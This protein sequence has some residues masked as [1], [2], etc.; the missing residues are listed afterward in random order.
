MTTGINPGIAT[1]PSM[2]YADALK[3][4]ESLGSRRIVV[5][6]PDNLMPTGDFLKEAYQ[7]V[8][9]H[10]HDLYQWA[11]S[12]LP[13]VSG[14]LTSAGKIAES[15]IQTAQDTLELAGNTAQETLTYAGNMISG[16]YP[17]VGNIVKGA[18]PYIGALTKH[19][20]PVLT[21]AAP[22]AIPLGQRLVS[23]RA[24][25]KQ[26]VLLEDKNQRVKDYLLS[27]QNSVKDKCHLANKRAQQLQKKRLHY[28]RLKDRKLIS[29][30]GTIKCLATIAVPLWT[31]GGTAALG[32]GLLGLAARYYTNRQEASANEAMAE[33]IKKQEALFTSSANVYQQELEK[34][35]VLQKEAE[36]LKIC[37]DK[38]QT[39]LTRQQIMS[40]QLEGWGGDLQTRLTDAQIHFSDALK[41]KQD[42]YDQLKTECDQLKKKLKDGQP[43]AGGQEKQCSHTEGK[44]NGADNRPLN[45]QGDNKPGNPAPP[46]P[47]PPPP[48]QT[49]GDA[50]KNINNKATTSSK[51]NF[52]SELTDGNHL[53]RLKQ[54]SPPIAK[55]VTK[56]PMAILMDDIRKGAILNP[57]P[58]PRDKEDYPKDMSPRDYLMA[59]L[60]T[61]NPLGRLNP[62]KDK[63]KDKN[64]QDKS[65]MGFFAKGLHQ[66]FFRANGNDSMSSIDSNDDDFE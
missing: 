57:A 42:Q 24:H 17:V 15:T 1:L 66:K 48:K 5:V 9:D 46:P 11:I 56:D 58:P 32:A 52:V 50:G 39:D 63:D 6:D 62:I 38:L 12:S 8:C 45:G 61:D 34:D 53:G 36:L 40:N 35:G 4:L 20:I 49:S 47:P 18:A 25:Q 30:P 3:Q 29:I 16:L 55:T 64:T 23:K 43:Q 33:K 21:L 60:K 14:M 27:D 59:D 2:S 26:L 19:A 54:C 51:G 31:V 65:N 7:S 13:Y 10:T 28:T 37:A 44:V 22:A 41:A